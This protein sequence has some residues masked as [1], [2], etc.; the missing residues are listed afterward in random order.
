MNI[1][2]MTIVCPECGNV[3]K[4]ELVDGEGVFVCECG[5]RVSIMRVDENNV[6]YV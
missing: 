6:I 3:M 5:W 2:Y 4:E 1:S